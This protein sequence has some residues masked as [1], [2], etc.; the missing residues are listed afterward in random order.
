MGFPSHPSFSCKEQGGQGRGKEPQGLVCSGH[1]GSAVGVGWKHLL[2]STSH[3]WALQVCQGQEQGGFLL[4]L[5]PSPFFNHHVP[6]NQLIPP[7]NISRS[8]ASCQ[9]KAQKEQ[10]FPTAH[11]CKDLLPF[12]LAMPSLPHATLPGLSPL[13]FPLFLPFLS[14]LPPVWP[15]AF[16]PCPFP[17]VSRDGT[18]CVLVPSS[19]FIREG[20]EKEK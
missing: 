2:T 11:F 13:L 7:S 14:L 8:R 3:P 9:G 1:G 5:C 15:T 4:L 10:S 19:A 18:D 17:G 6:K 20:E 12:F 16:S